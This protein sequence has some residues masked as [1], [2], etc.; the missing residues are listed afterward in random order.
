MSK[1]NTEEKRINRK[2]V[3]NHE[4]LRSLSEQTLEKVAGGDRGIPTLSVCS[5]VFCPTM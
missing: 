5:L 2:L 1:M 4:T 3:L